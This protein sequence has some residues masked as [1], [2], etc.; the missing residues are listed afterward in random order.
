MPVIRTS[1]EAR[2]VALSLAKAVPIYEKRHRF[3]PHF[4]PA[5]EGDVREALAKTADP[6]KEEARLNEGYALRQGDWIYRRVGKLAQLPPHTEGSGESAQ[7]ARLR[8]ESAKGRNLLCSAAVDRN[9]SECARI[10]RTVSRK[11]PAFRDTAMRLAYK[12]DRMQAFDLRSATLA[13]EFDDLTDAI[14]TL[15]Q[16][17]E[18]A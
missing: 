16:A 6:E 2:A 10:L 9:W 3:R 11:A 7:D 8:R 15:D 17:L 14:L 4:Q 18:V 13:P 5:T 1:D 12:C